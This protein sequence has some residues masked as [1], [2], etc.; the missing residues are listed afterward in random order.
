MARNQSAD[1]RRVLSRLVSKARLKRLAADIGVVLRERKIGVV[2]LFW[3][4]VLGF[5]TGNER[6]LAG[7]RRAFEKATGTTVVPSAFYNR[8]TPKLVRLL[9]AILGEVMDKTARM[10]GALRGVLR[11]L[12]ALF[13]E[14]E[15]SKQP[16]A[17][18]ILRALMEEFR[19]PKDSR[20]SLV[21]AF[22]NRDFS[23]GRAIAL[24]TGSESEFNIT[25]KPGDT[26]AGFRVEDIRT[27]GVRLASDAQTLTLAVGKSLIQRGDANWEVGAAEPSERS[28]GARTP[29]SSGGSIPSGASAPSAAGA[30]ADDVL[31][32][33]M[34]KRRQEMG[35]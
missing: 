20:L 19:H 3:T 31:K 13:P 24:F 15:R 28:E 17:F 22:I 9:K 1:I 30:G 8:F 11:P 14:E 27:D 32:R 2:A 4:L 7:L 35:Q 6:T 21:G 23:G 29:D 18:S 5:A 12:P 33:L 26:I 34:E 16:S 25:A 10:N